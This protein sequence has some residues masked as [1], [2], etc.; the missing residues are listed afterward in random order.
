MSDFNPDSFIKKYSGTTSESSAA[1]AV[2]STASSTFNPDEFIDKS[3]VEQPSAPQPGMA[4]PQGYVSGATGLGEVL[5]ELATAVKPIGQ[6]VTNTLGGYV[7]TPIQA[8]VDLGAM[9]M[10]FPPPYATSQG[11][12]GLY[13]TY[14]GVKEAGGN[15]ARVAG[16]VPEVDQAA[17]Y[18]LTS[19]LQ[20]AELEALGELATKGGKT[21]LNTFELPAR[22]AGDAEA[23]A[24]LNTLKANAA[25]TSA[26]ARLGGP[27]LRGVAKVA[28]P[29]GLA[30]N[31]YEAGQ[32]ARESELGKRLAEGQ[33]QQA[34]QAY[35]NMAVNQNVSGYRPSG[36]EA[37]NLLAS[38]DQRTIQMYGGAKQLAS[39]ASQTQAQPQPVNTSWIDNAMNL[40]RKYRI[41]PGQ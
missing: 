29:A 23:V 17:F 10:G 39:M 33:A 34:P 21:A 7:K 18:A 16:A 24:A 19:K 35:R 26:L 32:Y 22:L 40:A 31:A 14:K 5:P 28:G 3:V 20:P 36:Q 9:H 30:Y 4:L 25:E 27:M 1:S 8:A 11:V 41:Q 38:G 2:S 13:N 6:A 15:L 37:A 12:Q